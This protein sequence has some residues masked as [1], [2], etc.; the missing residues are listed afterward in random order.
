[1]AE[2]NGEIDSKRERGGRE[3]GR[4]REREHGRER[5]RETLRR[6]GE[7]SIL[8]IMLFGCYPN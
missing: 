8:K 7:R 3:D 2:R 5:E 6:E 4:E 1:M